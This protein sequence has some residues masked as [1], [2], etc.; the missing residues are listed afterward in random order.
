[1][2]I[3]RQID[4]RLFLLGFSNTKECSRVKMSSVFTP[5]KNSGMG[6]SARAQDR[7]CAEISARTKAEQMATCLS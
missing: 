1:M 6:P 3:A 5:A 2:S 7:E 4:L